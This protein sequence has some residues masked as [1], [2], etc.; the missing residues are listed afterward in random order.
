M[1]KRYSSASSPLN[2]S[3]LK[4]SSFVLSHKGGEYRILPL[5]FLSP[6]FSLL[7]G[8]SGDDS[9]F[10]FPDVSEKDSET[11]D[12]VGSADETFEAAVSDSRV[13]SSERGRTGMV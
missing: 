2:V 1:A 12:S 3:G 11:I 10:L 7:G 13:K 9:R 8:K 6:T 5:T 4:L